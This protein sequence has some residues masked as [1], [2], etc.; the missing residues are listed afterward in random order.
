MIS[1]GS[2][3][4]SNQ[5]ITRWVALL[6]EV[7]EGAVEGI[8]LFQGHYREGQ[9]AKGALA[10]GTKSC[11]RFPT[12]DALLRFSDEAFLNLEKLLIILL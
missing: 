11:K 2:W 7:D 3:Y 6:G 5:R 9:V 8:M 4:S 1:A 10:L 12:H